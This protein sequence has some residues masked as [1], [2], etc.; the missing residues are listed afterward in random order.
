[1]PLF[2]ATLAG[3]LVFCG[4]FGGVFF[5]HAAVAAQARDRLP[6][7]IALPK[8]YSAT[9]LAGGAVSSAPPPSRGDAAAPRE[10]VK[11]AARDEP[12]LPPSAADGAGRPAAAA[13]EPDDKEK[14]AQPKGDVKVHLFG[15]VEFRSKLKDMPQWERVISEERKKPGLESPKGLAARWTALR[16]SLKSRKPMEQLVEVNKFF[17]RWPYRIDPDAYGILDYWATPREFMEKSGDCE[18]YA[19]AKFCALKQLG[20][21][22]DEMRIVVL[23]DTIRNLAHAVLAVY[24]DGE[25]YILDNLSNLILPHG[26]LKHYTPQFSVNEEYR[27]V[28]MAPKTK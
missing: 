20:F 15:T 5:P 23:K 10:P 12:D 8:T 27:W 22:P 11:G 3:C 1:M 28:H 4:G 6:G 16:E 26:R 25:A 2:C 14:W 18:D 7:Q 19:I 17:N 24:L 9:P 21:T 13:P